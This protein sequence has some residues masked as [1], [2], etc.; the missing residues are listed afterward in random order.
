MS[1]IF[2]LTGLPDLVINWRVI[3]SFNCKKTGQVFEGKSPKGFPSQI[4]HR[5]IV[6]LDQLNNA[7]SLDDLR[8]PASN[9]LEA[10]SGDREG[11]H[12]I[13]INDQWRICFHWEAGDAEQVEIT[14]YH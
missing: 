8:I 2:P 4:L 11:Q 13:R 10:L 9:R 1:A 7:M 14:D 6:K 3:K 5:S 12:S